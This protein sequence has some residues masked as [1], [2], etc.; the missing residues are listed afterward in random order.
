MSSL[1]L[2]DSGYNSNAS[3][4]SAD[5]LSDQETYS[6]GASKEVDNWWWLLI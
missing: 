1:K 6:E 4:S 2:I 5:S 3:D